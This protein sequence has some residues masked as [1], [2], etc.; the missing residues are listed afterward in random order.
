MTSTIARLKSMENNKLIDV[1][2]NYRQ[3]GYSDELRNGALAILKSREIDELEL[4]L[5]GNFQNL[6]YDQA[7]ISYDP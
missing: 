3:Y 2:R 7:L 4:K 6:T 1:V 5:T